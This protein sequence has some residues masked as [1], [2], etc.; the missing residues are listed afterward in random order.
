M[1]ENLQIEKISQLPQNDSVLGNNDEF[2]VNREI[3]PGVVKTR[4]GKYGSIFGPLISGVQT[5]LANAASALGIA[6]SAQSAANA[7]N[8][9]IAS[10]ISSDSGNVAVLGTDSK[11]FVPGGSDFITLTT[12]SS[13]ATIANTNVE[14]IF[15]TTLSVVPAN[16]LVG[17][18]YEAH[19]N[20]SKGP[21]G[22]SS[23]IRLYINTVNN[24]TGSPVKVLE[25]SSGF[26]S[27]TS[28]SFMFRYFRNAV[29]LV[30]PRD[31]N[32]A[33]TVLSNL[34]TQSLVSTTPIT[35][36]NANTYFFIITTQMGVTNSNETL[37]FAKL[38]LTK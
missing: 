21:S 24:L 19:F 10:P 38:C 16:N 36:S 17:A 8:A 18:M 9:W 2:I 37:Q 5:A 30:V 28:Y 34:T 1:A 25:Y 6:N 33:Q 31:V 15:P 27:N 4:K 22:H 14:T 32:A 35:F 13:A 20:I 29:G 23:T 3:S 26:N 12:L 11:I 7:A